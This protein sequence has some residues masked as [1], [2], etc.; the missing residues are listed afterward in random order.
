M[1]G[2]C[3]TRE[4]DKY[5]ILV[6]MFKGRDHLDDLNVDGMMLFKLNFKKQRG[7]GLNST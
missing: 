4:G 1:D 6:M 7:Y 5:R 2:T 3:G